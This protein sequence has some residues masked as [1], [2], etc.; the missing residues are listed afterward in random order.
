[1]TL[2]RVGSEVRFLL[3]APVISI[4]TKDLDLRTATRNSATLRERRLETG[5]E[6]G[7]YVHVTFPFGLIL[8]TPVAKNN[9]IR[10]TGHAP[11]RDK[12]DRSGFD[13]AGLHAAH[14]DCVRRVHSLC[15]KRGEEI[16][17]AGPT[18]NAP[19]AQNC[20]GL[21]DACRTRVGA[22]SCLSRQVSD[23]PQQNWAKIGVVHLVAP[24]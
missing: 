14:G 5:V 4:E 17:S 12:A 21:S 10:R 23:N 20:Y 13:R 1:M 24:K 22:A 2:V 11:L 9:R 19:M 7:Q 16:C 6:R 18:G 15:R 3:A 8:N